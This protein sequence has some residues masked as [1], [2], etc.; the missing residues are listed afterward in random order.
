MY[1]FYFILFK[2]AANR[3]YF[4]DYTKQASIIFKLNAIMKELLDT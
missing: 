4:S 2:F 3:Y 1:G